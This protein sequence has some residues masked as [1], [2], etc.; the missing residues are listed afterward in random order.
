[1]KLIE[2]LET[3]YQHTSTSL[4]ETPNDRFETSTGVR[5]GGPESPLLY[6]LFMDYVMRVFIEEYKKNTT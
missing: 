3:L 5:Q 2:L 4:A 1:M 6:N